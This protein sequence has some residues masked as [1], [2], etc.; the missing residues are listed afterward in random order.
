[1]GDDLFNQV[2]ELL[3]KAGEVMATIFIDGTKIVE[4]HC[5]QTPVLKAHVPKETADPDPA[6]EESTQGTF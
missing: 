1:M 6:F 3:V 4:A 5:W 2:V